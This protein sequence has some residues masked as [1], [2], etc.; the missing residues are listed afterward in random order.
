MDV[1]ALASLAGNTLVT[2][3]VTDA[4]EDVRHK[5]AKIFGRGKTDPQI[6]EKFIA[7]RE[8]L[9]AA[10]SPGDVERARADLAAS[11]TARVRVLLEDYPDASAELDA[12]VKHIH[13]SASVT[14][15]HMVKAGRDVNITAGRRGIAAGVIHGNV[16]MGPTRPD[17]VSS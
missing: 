11:W 12:L 2:A 14:S 8:A 6:E 9:E 15:D 7:T 1:A 13:A 16:D 4:W 3:A 17:P 10:R 5:I